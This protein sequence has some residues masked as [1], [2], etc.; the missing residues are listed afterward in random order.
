MAVHGLSA[1]WRG[2]KSS[3]RFSVCQYWPF[4][5]VVVDN[6]NWADNDPFIAQYFIGWN[7]RKKAEA[8][9]ALLNAADKE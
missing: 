7:A 2:R 9:A 1:G 3:P 8:I 4:C 5:W 6:L